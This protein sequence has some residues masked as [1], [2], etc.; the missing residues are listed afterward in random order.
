[1]QICINSQIIELMSKKHFVNYGSKWIYRLTDK[2]INLMLLLS[3]IILWSVKCNANTA[4]DPL[5]IDR[6]CQYQ[7]SLINVM[8]L[9]LKEKLSA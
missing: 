1:M 5:F 8:A 7:N 9:T 6:A 3:E 4:A 2:G